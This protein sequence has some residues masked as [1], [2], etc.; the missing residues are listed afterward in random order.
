MACQEVMEACLEKMDAYLERKEPTPV[1]VANVA[2]HPEIPNDQY[3]DWHLAVRCRRQPK[4]WA[5]DDGGSRKKLAAARRWMPR[6]AVPVQCK[7]H[8]HKGLTVDK[9]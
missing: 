5:Q 4:K 8:S 2:A 3:G 6:H 7:V 1:E 9:R